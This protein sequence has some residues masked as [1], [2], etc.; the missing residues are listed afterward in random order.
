MTC[1]IIDCGTAAVWLEAAG[2]KEGVVG[3]LL[4]ILAFPEP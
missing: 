2:N 1:G 3:E 4:K